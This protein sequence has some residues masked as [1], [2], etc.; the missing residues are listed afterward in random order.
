M[1]RSRFLLIISGALLGACGGDD[2]CG[3]MGAP[4]VGLVASSAMVTLTFGNLTA[5]ENNDCPATG[6]PAG[7]VS[8]TLTGAQTDGTGLI[9]L[10]I[11]RPDQLDTMALALGTD[12]KLV[13]VTGTETNGTGVACSYTIDNTQA[14]TGTATGKGVCDNGSDATGFELIVNGSLSLGRTC[15]TVVDTTPVTLAGTIAVTPAPS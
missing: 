11:G 15:G 3:T 4:A 12:V 9:T 5:S 6:A 13:D 10:C 14:P 1:S 2:S 7:V 8:L